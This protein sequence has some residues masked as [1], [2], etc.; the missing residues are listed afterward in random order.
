MVE[1]PEAAAP[2][3]ASDQLPRALFKSWVLLLR[4]WKVSATSTVAAALLR[5]VGLWRM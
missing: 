5:S 2:P 4:T 1:L 3:P